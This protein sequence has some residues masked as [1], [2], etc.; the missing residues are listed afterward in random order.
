[1]IIGVAVGYF[2]YPAVNPAPSQAPTTG[3]PSVIK[4][5]AL[6]SLSGDLASYGQTAK[7]ALMLAQ[8]DINAYLNST[9]P[10]VQVQFVVEDTATKPDQALSELQTL[11]AQGIKFFIGPT[12]SAELKKYNQLCRKQ[13]VNSNFYFFNL[14][15]T[16]SKQAIY[17][18]NGS[19]R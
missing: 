18:Q 15:R 4:I 12:T 19:Y 16:G 7:A 11:A 13:S 2:V 1:L 5:G 14:C 9:R 10:G 3:L 17:I 8:Q 6:L